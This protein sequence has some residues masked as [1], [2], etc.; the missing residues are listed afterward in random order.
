MKRIL[1]ALLH[2]LFEFVALNVLGCS[3]IEVGLPM[4][5]IQYTAFDTTMLLLRQLFSAIICEWP[6]GQMFFLL[7]KTNV[8]AVIYEWKAFTGSSYPKNCWRTDVHFRTSTTPS[9]VE[10]DW[11][12]LPSFRLSFRDAVDFAMQLTSRL[13]FRMRLIS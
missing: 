6:S 10:I 2:W 3:T 7:I 5:K 13:I 4:F 8:S 12:L 1:K 11:L 9:D